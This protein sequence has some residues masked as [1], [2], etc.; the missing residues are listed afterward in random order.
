MR[1]EIATTGAGADASISLD[2][3]PVPV[4][5]INALTLTIT[6]Q[7]PPRLDLRFLVTRRTEVTL[8]DAE[9]GV[10]PSVAAVLRKLGW[11]PPAPA[12]VDAGDQVDAPA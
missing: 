3:V 7:G 8:D 6:P 12:S 11:T 5:L 9:V 1:A 2:G 10:D 4:G